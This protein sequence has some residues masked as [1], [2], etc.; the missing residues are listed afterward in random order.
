MVHL[1]VLF[2]S[3]RNKETIFHVSSVN[4]WPRPTILDFF[5]SSAG[6]PTIV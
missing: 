2:L 5:E 6:R 3:L 1:V 4:S